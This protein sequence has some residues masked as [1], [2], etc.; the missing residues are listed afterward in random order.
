MT[1]VNDIE[2]YYQI[3]GEGTPLILLHG[4]LGYSGHWKNE[5][6]VLSEHYR[7]IAVDSRGHGRSTSSER[8]ISYALMASDIV[9]LMDYL[10]VEKAHVLGWSDGGRAKRIV[11]SRPGLARVTSKL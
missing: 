10:D 11:T 3:H 2:L 8:R 1:P 7:V 5:V 9:A 6:S 4:G